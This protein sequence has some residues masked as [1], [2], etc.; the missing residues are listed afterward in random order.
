M[1][2]HRGFTALLGA[3]CLWGAAGCFKSSTFQASSESS[4]DS[5]SSFSKS[6][7][8][9]DKSDT[10]AYERDVRD[11]TARQA[12][13][14]VPDVRGVERD[15]G[16]VAAS[17]GITDW[18]QDPHTYVGIGQGLAKAGVEEPELGRFTTALSHTDPR[19]RD[20]IRAGYDA[21]PR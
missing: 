8:G 18:E 3:L 13:A 19:Y 12:A 21:A 4:S 2:R 17:H 20:W 11:A 16:A 5:S 1:R 9:D 15:V 10:Q 6:S 14:G 7:S